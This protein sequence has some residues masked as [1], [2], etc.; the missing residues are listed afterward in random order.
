[1]EE[2]KIFAPASVANVSCGFD[3]LGFCL[4]PVGDVMHVSKTQTPGV[5]IGTVTGQKLP[6]DPLKNVASVAVSAL[7]EAHPSK[8][9]FRIDIDKRIK[10]GSGIGSSAASAAGAVFAVNEL[11]GAP[12][13]RGE[14]VQFAMAGEAL[15][16]GAAHAD[17]LAPVLLGGFTLVRCNATLDIIKLPTPPDLVASVIHPKIELKTIHSRAILKSDIPLQKGVAQWGNLG[18]FISALYTEDY[19]L[20]SR[21]M[22]DEVIEPL[23]AMLIPKFNEVKQAALDAGALGSGISGSG[24]SIFALS[25]GRETAK[26]VGDAMKTFYDQIGL[27]HDLH[28]SPI[29]QQGIKIL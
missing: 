23:R 16:S 15:A 10:P 6:K 1:M 9:G 18:A 13:S 12:Y 4:D 26:K 5:Q 3:V 11:L 27:D 8:G 20:L 24:P 14:L 2:I 28:L 21:S 19:E 22:Q 17:N 29:N 25:R 7:L